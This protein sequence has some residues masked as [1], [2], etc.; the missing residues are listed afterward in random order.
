VHLHCVLVLDGVLSEEVKLDVIW[1]Y[2]L[3]VLTLCK[4]VGKSC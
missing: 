2:H 1:G 4:V 3:D